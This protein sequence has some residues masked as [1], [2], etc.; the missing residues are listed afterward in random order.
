[1]DIKIYEEV[2]EDCFMALALTADGINGVSGT[3]TYSKAFFEI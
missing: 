2:Q 3:A 1:M